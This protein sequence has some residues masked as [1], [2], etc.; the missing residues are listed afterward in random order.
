MN[1][2]CHV[3]KFRTL[4][5]WRPFLMLLHLALFINLLSHTDVSEQ[6]ARSTASQHIQHPHGELLNFRRYFYF[7]M[8]LK[9]I[10]RMMDIKVIVVRL[11]YIRINN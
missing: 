5:F 8:T 11:Y 4:S 7:E 6:L 1:C 2:S 10:V 3:G 9:K